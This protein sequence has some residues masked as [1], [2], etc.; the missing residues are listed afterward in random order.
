[1]KLKS[2]FTWTV[3]QKAISCKIF[4]D[5]RDI[6]VSQ[7]FQNHWNNGVFSPGFIIDP[8]RNARTWGLANCREV[9]TC[10]WMCLVDFSDLWPKRTKCMSRREIGDSHRMGTLCGVRETDH[11]SA[12][13][14]RI[15][16][17][18]SSVPTW[19]DVCTAHGGTLME[20]PVCPGLTLLFCGTG[21]R[22]S[23]VHG[24]RI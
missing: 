13:L 7:L 15:R 5:F 10:C 22:Y 14:G 20:C 2:Y 3:H 11:E 4:P 24:S 17:A 21:A 12:D 19:D 16:V 8:T 23:V 18:R 9:V 6:E 1:M